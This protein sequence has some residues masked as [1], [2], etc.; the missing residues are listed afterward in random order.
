VPQS[1]PGNPKLG[2]W[3]GKQRAL[4]RKNKLSKERVQ[5]MEDLGVIWVPF[6]TAWEEMFEELKE[7]QKKHDHCYVP[8]SYTENPQLGKWVNRQRTLKKKNKLSKE[9]IQQLDELIFVWQI[10]KSS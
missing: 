9:R 7:Y 10:K 2:T 4:R 8:Q 5:R 3:V 1:Y 6:G